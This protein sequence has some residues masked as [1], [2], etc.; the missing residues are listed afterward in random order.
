MKRERMLEIIMRF[1]DKIYKSEQE[2]L[3]LGI[4]K[5]KVGK[6]T[7]PDRIEYK[8]IKTL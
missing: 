4:S 2:G 7:G 6:A 3:K 8:I 1:Y 5:L